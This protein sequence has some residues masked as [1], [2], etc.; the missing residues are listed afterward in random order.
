MH[1]LTRTIDDVKSSRMDFV[2]G[3]VN[4]FCESDSESGDGGPSSIGDA[5]S[6]VEVLV[7]VIK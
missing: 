2:N 1:T 6:F 4:M 5:Q 7:T 3:L